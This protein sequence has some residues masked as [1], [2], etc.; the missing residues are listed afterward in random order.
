MGENKITKGKEWDE[1]FLRD[2]AETKTPVIITGDRLGKVFAGFIGEIGDGKLDLHSLANDR[3]FSIPIDG[4]VG[5]F[6]ANALVRHPK[7]GTE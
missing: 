6:S 4:I 5:L 7:K 1:G 2:L 3:V